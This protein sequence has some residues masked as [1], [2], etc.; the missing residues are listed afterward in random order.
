M[1]AK[2]EKLDS[3]LDKYTTLLASMTTGGIGACVAV[4]ESTT[5]AVFE[6]YVHKALE[7]A[8]RPGQVVVLDN[9]MVHKGDRVREPVEERGCELLFLPPYSPNLNPIEE[10]FAKVKGAVAPV[11]RAHAEGPDRGDGE[12]GGCGDGSGRQRALRVLW[13]PLDG[14]ISMPTALSSSH[15]PLS[16]P[17]LIPTTIESGPVVIRPQIGAVQHHCNSP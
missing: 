14:S 4:T 16:P 17:Y 12:G 8:L 5:A 9:L 6:A 1:G 2:E 11:R 15:V 13:L 3:P 10:A 7:P